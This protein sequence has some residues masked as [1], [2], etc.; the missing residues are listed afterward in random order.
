[1]PQR[2]KRPYRFTGGVRIGNSACYMNFGTDGAMT[3][4]GAGITDSFPSA[5]AGVSV[6]TSCLVS[7]G[8]VNRLGSTTSYTN[9]SAC[10]LQTMVGAGRVYKEVWLPA[11]LWQAASGTGAVNMVTGSPAHT[12]SGVGY[13]ARTWTPIAD[14]A[15]GAV[16]YLWVTPPDICSTGSI[17]PYIEVTPTTAI[18]A[19]S[20]MAK[21]TLRY[22]LQSAGGGSDGLSACVVLATTASIN[23][24]TIG[25]RQTLTMPNIVSASPGQFLHMQVVFPVTGACTNSGSYLGFVGL[26]L[27]YV[28]DRIGASGV[29]VTT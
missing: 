26:R 21:P 14:N 7:S 5:C 9:T 24:G 1:M 19:G 25:F 10:G 20:D 12:I 29:L 27:R 16:E 4:T 8:S 28:A 2:E 3:R 23:P 11:D 6:I 22:I 15:E 17:I 18:A 13:H